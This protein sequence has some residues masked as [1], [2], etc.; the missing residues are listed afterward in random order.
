MKNVVS[1]LWIVRIIQLRELGWQHKWGHFGN[2]L[3][4]YAFARAYAE[5]HDCVLEVNQDWPGL[6][7]FGLAHP[8][9]SVELPV[10]HDRD[11]VDG[12][13]NVALVGFFQ[14]QRRVDILSKRKVREWFKF[15]SDYVPPYRDAYC[16]A[17]YRRGNFI[18]H[19]R[20]PAI[21]SDLSY[22]RAF[23]KFDAHRV[24]RISDTPPGSSLHEDFQILMHAS[25]LFRANSS[26]S[27]WAAALNERGIVYSPVVG[28]K[29]GWADVDFIADADQPRTGGTADTAWM[30]D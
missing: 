1:F 9:P 11:L 30:P 24:I 21:I 12:Q 13:I 5:R 22:A 3:F 25:K 2:H 18:G 16:A 28:G 4:Q 8:T 20:E 19:P 23:E 14:D 6:K 15:A 17:H 26:F 7:T 29:K 10:V 27:W